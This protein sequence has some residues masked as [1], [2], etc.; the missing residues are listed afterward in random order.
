MAVVDV[1]EQSLHVPSAL[2][3]S[4]F[5]LLLRCSILQFLS[6]PPFR[7][8]DGLDAARDR[9]HRSWQGTAWEAWPR[10]SDVGIAMDIGCRTGTVRSGG[11]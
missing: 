2:F 4:R 10:E 9:E 8:W 5:P 3:L 6:G 1:L 7:F 11:A